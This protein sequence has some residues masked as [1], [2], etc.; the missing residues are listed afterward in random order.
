MN[1]SPDGRSQPRSMLALASSLALAA[2]CAAVSVKLFVAVLSVLL[3]C[4]LLTL[5]IFPATPGLPKRLSTSSRLAFVRVLLRAARGP[6]NLLSF[7]SL[8][9]SPDSSTLIFK[10]RA[11][12]PLQDFFGSLNCGAIASAV[13]VTT[14]AAIVACGGFPGVSTSLGV[15]FVCGCSPGAEIRVEAKVSMS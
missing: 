2:L 3:A 11:A 15:T 14:T 12:R 6:Y 1:G 8:D 10:L 4:L 13:D 9:A 7:L 5:T